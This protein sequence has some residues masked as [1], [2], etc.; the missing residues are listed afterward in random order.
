MNDT[1]KLIASFKALE[2]RSAP[3]LGVVHALAR[4]VL[5]LGYRDLKS[6]PRSQAR[7]CLPTASPRLPGF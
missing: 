2:R 6:F 3:T 5:E 1:G 7:H 4:V